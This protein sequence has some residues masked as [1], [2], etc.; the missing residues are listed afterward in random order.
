[1]MVPFLDLARI[2]QPLKQELLEAIGNLI[3]KSEFVLGESVE[4]FESAFADYC[5]SDFAIS[6]NSGTSALHLALVGLGI[7]KGDEVIV[8]AMTFIATAAAVSYTGATPKFVD[9][10]RNTWNID[11]CKIEQAIT[12]RTRAIIPVHLHG[13]MADMPSILKIAEKY[14]L[15]VIEDAAQAHGASIDGRG[16][17]TFGA[18]GCFSF[19]PGKNLGALGEGGAVITD[20]LHL[21][22]QVKLLRNWGSQN[23]YVHQ[24]VA[25]N[26]RLES[27]QAAALTLKLKYLDVWTSQRQEA[28]NLYHQLLLDTDYTMSYVPDG[29]KHVHHIFAVCTKDRSR[30]TEALTSAG[31]GWGIHYPIPLHLQPAYSSLNY[32]RGEF[33]ESERLADEWISLPLFPGITDDE[34]QR[35][36]AILKSI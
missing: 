12:P 21:C 26:S 35:V 4:H 6:V 14:G 11:T 23:K 36:V 22:N 20:D 5:S 28:R 29:Y 24:V 10:D 17:G 16:A 27:L 8:P 13:L 25:Y 3:D 7:G 2:H 30:V 15:T 32:Q 9:V 1:M 34:V 19:Y 33:P 18:A 31:I